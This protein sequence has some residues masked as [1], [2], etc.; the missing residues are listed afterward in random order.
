[1]NSKY[2]REVYDAV[3]QYYSENYGSTITADDVDKMPRTDVLEIYLSWE[4][5]IGY[6]GTICSILDVR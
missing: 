3:I 1:M 5:V 2:T 6:T 4:G